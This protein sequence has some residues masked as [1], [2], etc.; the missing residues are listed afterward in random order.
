V[1]A[2]E[3]RHPDGTAVGPARATAAG[4][5]AAQGL[6]FVG[7]GIATAITVGTGKA[8]DGGSAALAAAFWMLA[9]VGLGLV[10]WA[11]WRGRHWARSPSLVWQLLMLPVGWSLLDTQSVIGLIVLVS[12]VAALIALLSLEREAHLE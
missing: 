12:A 1:P 2:T 6:T 11:L 5:T 9:G 4:V 10:A 8:D 3:P 7:L